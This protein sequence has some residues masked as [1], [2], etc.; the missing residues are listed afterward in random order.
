MNKETSHWP[1]DADLERIHLAT[2]G[3][4][5]RHQRRQVRV[6]TATIG[7]GAILALGATAGAVFVKASSDAVA[8][9]T[10]CYSADS[11]NADH[12]QAVNTDPLS[13]TTAIEVCSLAWTNGSLTWG[14]RHQPKPGSRN[15]VPE[16][17]A[18]LRPDNVIGVFPSRAGD[19]LEGFC[20]RL[21]LRPAP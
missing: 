7:A 3:S 16:L 21:D 5:S 19:T 13:T 14:E 4:I 17:R 12:V 11:K 15:P 1:T 8:N 18:C 20:D 6:R 9:S 2:R 10:Y